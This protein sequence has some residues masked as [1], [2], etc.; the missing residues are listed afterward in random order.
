[1]CEA[2]VH[3]ES[4]ALFET[5]L[6]GKKTNLLALPSTTHK[7]LLAQPAPIALRSIQSQAVGRYVLQPI[8]VVLHRHC[9]CCGFSPVSQQPWL[10]F[11]NECLPLQTHLCNSGLQ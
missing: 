3:Q 6:E 9:Q 11:G 8:P 2:Q 5:V 4:K 7:T 1:M 10:C